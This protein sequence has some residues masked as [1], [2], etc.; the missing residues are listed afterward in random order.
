MAGKARGSAVSGRKKLLRLRRSGRERSVQ[1]HAGLALPLSNAAL[2]RGRQLESVWRCIVVCAGGE[3]A[4]VKGSAKGAAESRE[5]N[6]H[7]AGKAR[8]KDEDVGGLCGRNGAPRIGPDVG[9]LSIPKT[10]G[11]GGERPALH[12]LLGIGSFELRAEQHQH[13]VGV[14]DGGRV[15]HGVGDFGKSSVHIL[16]ELYGVVVGGIVAAALLPDAGALEG[17]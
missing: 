14:V 11:A 3:H 10:L 5:R 15:G 1:E 9:G 6:G 2:L 4:V 16:L 17:T 12:E 13:L 7:S 8:G